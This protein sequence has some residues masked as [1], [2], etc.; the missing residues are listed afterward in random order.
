[1]GTGGFGRL[2]LAQKAVTADCIGR[3]QKKEQQHPFTFLP[4]Y[5]ASPGREG[6]MVEQ[7]GSLSDARYAMEHVVRL[8]RMLD[9]RPVG[10]SVR[11]RVRALEQAALRM[12]LDARALSVRHWRAHCRN[13]I[14]F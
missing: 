14:R 6:K 5:L 1:V 9:Y 11:R 4:S 3:H 10:R 2:S 7:A 12:E 13:S 8:K